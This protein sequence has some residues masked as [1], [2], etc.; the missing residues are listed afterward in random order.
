MDK[1]RILIMNTT[2][3]ILITGAIA[4]AVLQS[5]SG[6]AAEHTF[7]ADAA[8]FHDSNLTRAQYAADV[9]ADAGTA[10][11]I[12]GGEFFAP[13]ASD[14][15]TIAAFANG[16]LYRRYRGLDNV[17]LGFRAN[18]RHKLGLGYEAPWIAASLAASHDDYRDSLRDSNRVRIELEL[19]Q[20]YGRSFDA[21]GGVVYDR[22]Y[23]HHGESL[24]PGIPGT[25]FDLRG[26]GGFARVGYAFNDALYVDAKLGVRRGDV[27]S[28]AQQSL[29][30][31]L[32][33][34]AIAADPVFGSSDLYAYRLDGTTWT[35]STA[36][37]FALDDRS[38]LNLSYADERTYAAYGNQYKSRLVTVF[39][40]YRQ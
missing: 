17:V 37:S 19:G 14:T 10:L 40:S 11:R 27:E 29:Q 39:Y 5:A 1:L 2:K 34:T 31:F 20:R 23:D 22:R 35:A 8:L 21:S 7:A 33:S 16:E 13:T 32:V 3:S 4:F 30:I 9:R 28:T 12:D 38:S 24:V 6:A 25:V 36:A 18:A 26:V 15:F